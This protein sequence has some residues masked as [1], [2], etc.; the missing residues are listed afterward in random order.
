MKWFRN[1]RMLNETLEQNKVKLEKTTSAKTKYLLK[2]YNNVIKDHLELLDE[3]ETFK[4]KLEMSEK[5]YKN[6]QELYDL[7]TKNLLKM[8]DGWREQREKFIKIL[9]E[10]KV[11]FHLLLMHKLEDYNLLV[12]EKNRLLQE[13]YDFLKET[14]EFVQ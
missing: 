4:T 10:K 1:R 5:S 11:D 14:L 2:D 12:C 3:N 9:T 8:I 13:E 6:L 7:D